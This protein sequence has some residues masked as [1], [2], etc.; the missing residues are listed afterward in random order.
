MGE[1]AVL[2]D[3]G[4]CVLKEWGYVLVVEKGWTGVDGVQEAEWAWAELPEFLGLASDL[5][6][7]T[8]EVPG[9]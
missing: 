7:L 1:R 5:Q 8:W 3:L 2:L 9:S 4:W 6:G